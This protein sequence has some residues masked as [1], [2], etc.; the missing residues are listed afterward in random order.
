MA[1]L[2]TCH[3]GLWLGWQI[4]LNLVKYDSSFELLNLFIAALVKLFL[5]IYVHN[6]YLHCFCM[7]IHLYLYSASL[8][9][10]SRLN[11]SNLLI[12]SF[13]T[14]FRG[15]GLCSVYPSIYFL[16]PNHFGC[17]TFYV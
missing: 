9:F 12:I 4:L 8:K 10:D 16:K 13:I 1:S 5:I 11:N 3:L 14:T 6:L 17:L 15:M 7:L 2:S